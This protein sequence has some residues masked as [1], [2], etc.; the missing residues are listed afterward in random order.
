MCAR[1]CRPSP[2]SETAEL[3]EVE[4]LESCVSLPKAGLQPAW[5]A[6]LI[7]TRRGSGQPSRW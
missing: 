1:L 7:D 3:Q 6:Q 5:I 4:V 2:C